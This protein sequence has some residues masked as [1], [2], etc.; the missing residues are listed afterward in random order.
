MWVRSPPGVLFIIRIYMIRKRNQICPYCGQIMKN[1][2]KHYKV[3]EKKRRGHTHTEEEKK[4]ISEKRKQYL[5]EH[6][7]E[8][9]WKRG[10][11]FIS[12]PCEK[13]KEVLKQEGFNFAE[14]YSDRRWEHNY[15][16]DIAFLD[17]K[18]AIEIN[19]N[20][21]YNNDGTLKP[22]YQ[23]RHNYLISEGWFILE[24]HYANCYKIEKINEIKDAIKNRKEIDNIEHQ[25]LFTNRIK[26][27]KEKQEEKLKK[28]K[29]A[30]ENG[31]IKSDGTINGH[32]ITNIEWNNRKDLILNSGIDLT[33]FGWVGKVIEK[34][35][36]TKRI[37]EDTV[38]RFD[39]LKEICFYRK[40]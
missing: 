20:Q 14:E 37:I 24:I 38:K 25:L 10:T 18:L 9:P 21:H 34:T 16:I 29:Y 30:E 5:Q 31:L 40:S 39:E 4:L 22:Y 13:L 35:G 6:P 33:K 17:K 27:I 32:G 1:I 7:D 3:C 2:R 12:V 26:T 11:K 23:N 19:G 28:R 8:H 15:S 36:L